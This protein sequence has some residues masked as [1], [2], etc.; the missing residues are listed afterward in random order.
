LTK[1]YLKIANYG[2]NSFVTISLY[3]VILTS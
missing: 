1:Y 3:L 2:E